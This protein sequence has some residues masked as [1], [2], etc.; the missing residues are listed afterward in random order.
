M[1]KKNNQPK[2]WLYFSG[3]GLQMAI[4]I[5]GAVFLGIWLDKT[6][7]DSKVFTIALSLLGII[8]ALTQVLTSLNKFK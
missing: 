8:I 7:S 4:I 6:Y 5:S 1:P 3:I 2:P